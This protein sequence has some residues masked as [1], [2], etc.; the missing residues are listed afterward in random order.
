MDRRYDVLDDAARLA[1][2]FV[3][4]LPDR[5]VGARADLPELRRRITR[6]LGDEGEDPGTVLAE[7][8]HDVEPG[9][10]G[11][12]GPRYFGYVVGGALPAA[13]GAD[14]LTSAWDQNAGGLPRRSGCASCRKTTAADVDRSADAILAAVAAAAPA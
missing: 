5:P 8:A 14:W 13:I 10:V 12:P 2:A 7:L 3:D 11:S 9:L 1:R 4:T 6:P